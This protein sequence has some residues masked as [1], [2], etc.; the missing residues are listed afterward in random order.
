MSDV[1]LVVN[2]CFAIIDIFVCLF[3]LKIWKLF[4]D[5]ICSVKPDLPQDYLFGDSEKGAACAIRFFHC[6]CAVL[7]VVPIYFTLKEIKI[8]RTGTHC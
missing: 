2:N 6:N 3:A 5:Q 4:S 1:F 8:T 7:I